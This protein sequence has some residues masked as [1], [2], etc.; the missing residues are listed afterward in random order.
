MVSLLVTQILRRQ[1]CLISVLLLLTQVQGC[2]VGSGGYIENDVLALD[3]YTGFNEDRNLTQ[4]NGWIWSET[5]STP[6]LAHKILNDHID[7]RIPA[8][9][10]KVI[11]DANFPEDG[12]VLACDPDARRSSG[13]GVTA[14]TPENI[15]AFKP[16]FGYRPYASLMALNASATYHCTSNGELGVSPQYTW[17]SS[18]NIGVLGL[19]ITEDFQRWWHETVGTSSRRPNGWDNQISDG[20]EPTFM[21]ALERADVLDSAL[22]KKIQPFYSVGVNIGYYTNA[23]VGVGG[24]FLLPGDSN[25]S[26]DTPFYNVGGAYSF[27]GTEAIQSQ[28]VSIAADRFVFAGLRLRA[29]AR[30]YLLQGQ[31]RDSAVRYSRSNIEDA[32]VQA[33][34]GF[35]DS[36]N[37][38][39][40]LLTPDRTVAKI[41]KKNVFSCNAGKVGGTVLTYALHARTQEYKSDQEERAHIWAGLYFSNIR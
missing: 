7:Q 11:R 33:T 35:S 12:K 36:L 32:I 9:Q 39:C 24:R 21:Y 27:A 26:F 13:I 37:G 40:R 23:Y 38:W 18:L 16:Q 20:G 15:V 10:R 34:I 3:S 22:E 28:D 5:E 17:F 30:N 25:G 14:F 1:L 8:L 2:V 41:F 6:N 29:V 31:F 19:T 4:A